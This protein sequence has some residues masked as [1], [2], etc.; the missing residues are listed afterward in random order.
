VTTDLG[1]V[2]EDPTVEWAF[3]YRYPSNCLQL[4]RIF[5]GIRNDNQ[6]SKIPFRISRD[7]TG[8]LVYTDMEDATMEY[9]FKETDPG[10]FPADFVT[11]ISFLVAFKMAPRITRGDAVKLGSRAFE[12]YN[13]WMGMA[14]ANAA[15]E[16]TPERT[17]E[18]ELIRARD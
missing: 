9:I 8:L 12:A 18:S 6:D 3:S 17:P 1:L 7:E 4:K 5:S 11:A 13:M 10:R 14:R 2:E 15:N 16:E